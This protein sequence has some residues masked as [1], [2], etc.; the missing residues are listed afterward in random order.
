MFNFCCTAKWLSCTY[1]YVIF[2]ILFHYG[3]SQD[4]EYNSLCY[5]VEP[6]F[7]SILVNICDNLYLLIPNSQ[8]IHLLPSLL[9]ATTRLSDLY[10]RLCVCFIYRLICA[11]VFFF[12][13]GCIL[14]YIYKWYH[15]VL[16]FALWL[17]SLSIIISRSIH[18]AANGIISF[19]LMTE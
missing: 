2:H 3:L 8:S 10:L 19:F 14:D 16:S 18:V 4:I 13:F 5:T 9:L 11:G 15:I 6:C 7:L 12:F 1:M 17:T